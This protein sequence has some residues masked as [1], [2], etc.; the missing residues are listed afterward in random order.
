MRL[1]VTSAVLFSSVMFLSSA[2]WME[3]QPRH[4][5]IVPDP[6]RDAVR[7]EVRLT[8]DAR[9]GSVRVSG[10]APGE[11]FA[12]AQGSRV[13]GPANLRTAVLENLLAMSSNVEGSSATGAFRVVLTQVEPGQSITWFLNVQAGHRAS[14]EIFNLN[15]ESRPRLIDHF[16]GA[17]GATFST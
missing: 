7:V 3:A 10:A 9:F 12:V 2:V 15:D 13:T 14:I 17:V 5:P 8:T 16:E 11:H 4:Y 6:A 1:S